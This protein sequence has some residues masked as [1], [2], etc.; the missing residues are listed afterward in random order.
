MNEYPSWVEYVRYLG[1]DPITVWI[2]YR[3]VLYLSVI[4]AI[5]ILI[6]ALAVVAWQIKVFFE[7]YQHL[8][9]GKMPFYRAFHEMEGTDHPQVRASLWQVRTA[10]DHE[11]FVFGFPG[12]AVSD[13]GKFRNAK[14]LLLL[15]RTRLIFIGKDGQCEFA[16]DSFRDANVREGLRHIE[17]KL[18]F[19][20]KKPLF[21]LL[22]L[23]RDHAQEIFMRMHAFRIELKE[24][25]S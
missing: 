1:L 23:N 21:Y 25:K 14:G 6:A 13:V 24:K 19:E 15:T 10:L 7:N 16:L 20:D 22:G 8:F 12:I 18:I 9:V 5:L 4:G 17:L 11:D 2:E 3:T